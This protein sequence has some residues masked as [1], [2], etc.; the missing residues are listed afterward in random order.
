MNRI[1]RLNPAI[2]AVLFAATLWGT[3]G[4]YYDVVNRSVDVDQL[5]V[6]TLRGV[7]ATVV[8]VLWWGWR[9]R[10]VFRVERHDI[11]AF[12]VMGLVSVAAFYVFLIYAF[13]W[14]SVAV[15]TLLLYTAPAF[16]TLGAS[17]FLG[18]R[19]TR[20]RLA[21]LGMSFAGCALVVEIHQPGSVS[22]NIKGVAIGLAAALCYASYS[23]IAKPMLVRY[24]SHTV[25]TMHMV[26]GA[27]AL[28]MI[29]LVVSPTV[30][31]P[32]AATLILALVGGILLSVI[33]V[34]LYTFGLTHLPSS[35][36]SILAT[37]EPVVAVF[38]AVLV[39][40]ERLGLIQSI[41]AGLVVLAVIIL[42]RA[43]PSKRLP[44]IV[45]P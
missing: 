25:Q 20:I 27:L 21:A 3:L 43:M 4:I 10:S 28:L 16:V 32:L 31:P 34:A 14:T 40:D 22:G 33:P 2:A 11:P 6:V 18:E 1:G 19:V 39:L 17:L 36:A 42:G 44:V 24:R 7:G 38:L 5:T 30:W 41:G 15:G 29:K 45:E 23:L 12:V 9:D 37:W 35:D 8:L 26:F 13:V